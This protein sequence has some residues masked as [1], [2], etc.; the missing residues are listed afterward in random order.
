M[1]ISLLLALVACKA[2]EKVPLEEGETFPDITKDESAVASF[3]LDDWYSLCSG[4]DCS[5]WTTAVGNI[6]ASYTTKLITKGNPDG[7]SNV[8]V[9]PVSD[10]YSDEVNQEDT[11][12]Q[13]LVLRPPSDDVISVSSDLVSARDDVSCP[14]DGMMSVSSIENVSGDIAVYSACLSGF[15]VPSVFA[16]LYPSSVFGSVATLYLN[17]GE[18]AHG[19]ITGEGVNSVEGT[20]AGWASQD[21]GEERGVSIA[22]DYFSSAGDTGQ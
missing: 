19:E 22:E 11:V 18:G 21:L 5:S 17:V 2:P 4:A 9:I 15:G 13:G 20:F 7:T 12:G 3:A 1:P 10:T 16:T 6:F 8:F 14:N